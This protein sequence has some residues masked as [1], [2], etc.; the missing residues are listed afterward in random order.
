MMQS[1]LWLTGNYSQSH[2]ALLTCK[3]CLELG[4]LIERL[5]VGVSTVY[6]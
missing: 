6:R 5:W 2:P 1:Y 3:L 4:I